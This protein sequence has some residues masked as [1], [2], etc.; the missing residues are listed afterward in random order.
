MKSPVSSL[1]KGLLYDTNRN[2]GYYNEKQFL[3]EIGSYNICLASSKQTNK[4]LLIIRIQNSNI[5][6]KFYYRIFRDDIRSL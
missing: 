5:I 1:N 3:L 6:H 4:L 2:E